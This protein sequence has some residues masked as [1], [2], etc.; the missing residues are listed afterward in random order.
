[1]NKKGFTLVE[2]LAVIVILSLIITI[3]ATNGFGAFNNAKNKINEEGRKEITEGAKVFLTD[4]EFCDEKLNVDIFNKIPIVDT[5]S[6]LKM[7]D[8]LQSSAASCME[9]KLQILRELNYVSSKAVDDILKENNN[10]KVKVCLTDSNKTVT[11]IDWILKSILFL[12]K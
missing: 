8:D 2:L 5:D 7:C 4:V 12:L 1:M 6:D 3:V 9:I 11:I 10:I